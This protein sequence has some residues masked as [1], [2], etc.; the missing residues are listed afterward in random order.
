MKRTCVEDEDGSD[1]ASKPR[2]G[3]YSEEGVYR[4]K[5]EVPK[6]RLG[7]RLPR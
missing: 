4:A 2:L 1:P 5:K 7:R 3:I 6:Q